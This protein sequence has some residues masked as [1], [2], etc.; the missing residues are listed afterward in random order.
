MQNLARDLAVNS[1]NEE[2][3]ELPFRQSDKRSSGWTDRSSSVG[4]DSTPHP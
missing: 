3:A 1:V 4:P 2:V